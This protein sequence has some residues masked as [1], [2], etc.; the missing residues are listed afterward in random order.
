MLRG[1]LGDL[2]FY[3]VTSTDFHL[4]EYAIAV[5]PLTPT[6]I[7]CHL[8]NVYDSQAKW[9]TANGYF[10]MLLTK[11]KNSITLIDSYTRWII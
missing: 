4:N 8:Q 3:A 6:E 9:I 2:S 10:Y 1:I 5:L 7:G 11:L